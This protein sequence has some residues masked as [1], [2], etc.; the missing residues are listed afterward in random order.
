MAWPRADGDWAPYLP[1]V[2]ACYRELCA[3][4]SRH[5]PV[6]LLSATPEATAQELAHLGTG[7]LRVWASPAQDTWTR[8]YGPITVLES[9][10]PEG[11]APLLLDF[12]F[13]GWGGKYQAGGDN[14]AT[15]AAWH[16]GAFG[17]SPLEPV[18]LVLEGGSI[19]SDGTGTIFTTSSCLL[20]PGRNPELDQAAIEAALIAELGARRVI[21]LNHGE[22]CGDDTDGHIDTL[23]RLCDP[24]TLAYVSC[25]DPG[26]PA[27]APLQR[28]EAEL[29][30]LRNAAG[31]PY[32]L[33][34]L[35][36]PQARF[37]PDDGRRLP[38]TYANFLI[39]NGA[40]LVP[41]Y[42]DPSRDLAAQ[43]ALAKAFP[44]HTIEAIDCSALLLQHGSLHCATMQIP[45][46]VFQ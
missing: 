27:A 4:I 33:I 32:R 11:E 38:A 21:W 25:D 37:A 26:D 22:L 45:A 46:A 3:A 15:A 40:V 30:G 1:A 10:G 17:L 35:P 5:A 29:Q 12:R 19:E 23:V 43:A 14:R 9:R 18:E 44:C 36:W 28:L 16:G 42:S 6:L 24:G 13:N 8:D 34:P 41:S 31:G 39:L 20:S 7:R 2:R